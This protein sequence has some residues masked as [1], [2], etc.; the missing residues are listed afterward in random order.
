MDVG[1]AAA[2]TVTVGE[3]SWVVIT[4][5]LRGS[6]RGRDVSRGLRPPTGRRA[7]LCL[8]SGVNSEGVG[9]ED[10]VLV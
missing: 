10:L 4:G 9:L 2:A 6:G 1:S 8:R 5:V 7:G 3:A